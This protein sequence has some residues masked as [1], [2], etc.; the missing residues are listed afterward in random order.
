M[1]G[2]G[3]LNNGPPNPTFSSL[4]PV[5]VTLYP[6]DMTSHLRREISLGGPGGPMSSQ[7]S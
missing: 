6:A 3:Q 5:D 2:C 1:G 4:K 7:R